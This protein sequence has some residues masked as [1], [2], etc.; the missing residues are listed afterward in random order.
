MTCEQLALW[1]QTQDRLKRFL[2]KYTNDI[3]LAEDIIQ[4]VFIKVHDKLPQLRERDKFTAW[5]FRIAKNMIMDHFR[6]SATKRKA[7]DVDANDHNVN[8]NDCVSACLQEML[9]TLPEKYRKAVELAALRHVPQIDVA[10]ELKISYSG[11]KS[12]VQRAKQMVKEKMQKAYGLQFDAYGNAI[13]CA[14]KLPCGCS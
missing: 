10:R 8:L 4:D 5:I 1:N 9:Q 11:A 2:L 3:T 14:K 13:A 12:R 6:R 7:F